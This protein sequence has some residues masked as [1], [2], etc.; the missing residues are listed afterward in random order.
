MKKTATYFLLQCKRTAR[1]LPFVLAVT[2]VLNLGL[3]LVLGTLITMDGSGDDKQKITIGVVGNPDGGFLE[4]GISMIQTMDTSQFIMNLEQMTQEDARRAMKQGKIAAY[5]IIPDDF[6]GAAIRGDVQKIKYVTTSSSIGI[7]SIFKDEMLSAISVM[8][9]ESQNG[10]YGMQ[11]ALVSNGITQDQYS[12][13][14]KL[15]M[16]YLS[17][18]LG[19][20]STY[21]EEILGVSDQMSFAGYMLSGISVLML[22]LCGVSCCHLFV[23]KDMALPKL[24]RAKGH[25]ALGQ[26]LGEYGA[27]FLLMLVNVCILVGAVVTFAPGLTAMIPELADFS[28]GD[29][30]LI[31]VLFIPALLLITAIQFF[32]YETASN[33]VNGV[34]S[35]FLT[36]IALC[37]VGGCFYPIN[38]YS[39]PIQLLAKFLPSGMA[40][41]YLSA[42]MTDTCTLAG[43]ALLVAVSVGLMAAAAAVRNL[44]MVRA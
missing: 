6:I 5:V 12:H 11:N 44:R 7:T 29:L 38:F 17:L 37:Y 33:V 19:R 8:L 32:L 14:D 34:L 2:L 25:S 36:A 24:L 43:A 15:S 4:M 27:Y 41:S 20:S 1:S 39:E 35:Q 16:E 40:R 3:G 28:R 9:V 30:L 23:K 18:I 26:V 31:P 13:M 21:E 10:T 42:C 22:F